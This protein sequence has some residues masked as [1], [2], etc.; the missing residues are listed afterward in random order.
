MNAS[1]ASPGLS[2]SR[3]MAGLQCHK[4][5]YLETY[6]L[7]LRVPQTNPVARLSSA[8]TRSVLSR[9]IGIRAAH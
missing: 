7:N 2:K 6:R 5:L 3:F 4:R 9:E 1:I 8:G